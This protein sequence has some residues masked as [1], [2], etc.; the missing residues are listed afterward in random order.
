MQCVFFDQLYKPIT[1][2][3]SNPICQNVVLNIM[4]YLDHNLKTVLSTLTFVNKQISTNR[5]GQNT[6]LLPCL[7]LYPLLFNLSSP[8]GLPVPSFSVSHTSRSCGSTVPVTFFLMDCHHL[9]RR[10]LFFIPALFIPSLL[11][12]FPP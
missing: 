12:S 4:I 11:Q 5:T 7:Y 8:Y 9:K 10:V 3:F 6:Y 2:V 1:E